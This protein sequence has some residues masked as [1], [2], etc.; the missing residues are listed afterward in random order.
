VPTLECEVDRRGGLTLVE[1]IVHND[2]ADRRR[3]R[4][5]NRLDGPVRTPP[6]DSPGPAWADGAATCLLA[7][8]EHAA[9]GYASPAPP[10]EQPVELTHHVV[11][12]AGDADD[13]PADGD[14]AA[15]PTVPAPRPPDGAAAGLAAEGELEPA[16]G[17]NADRATGDEPRSA[18]EPVRPDGAGVALPPAIAAWLG[19]LERRVAAVERGRRDRSPGHATVVVDRETLA[20]LEARAA[21][22]N[23]RLAAVR[24]PGGT[25]DTGGRDGADCG[26]GVRGADGEQ[27]L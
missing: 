3:V 27:G 22:L 21:A 23:E 20:A 11:A 15:G 19:A 6:A 12:R 18:D 1:C 5:A 8:G 9:L 25:E 14:D 10:C 24:G 2:T 26:G 4:L 7:P 13:G 17:P 16:D